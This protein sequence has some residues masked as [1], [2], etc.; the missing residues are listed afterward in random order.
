MFKHEIGK[1]AKDLVTGFKGIINVRAQYFTGCNRYGLISKI[2]K[3]GKIPET[4]WF[5]ENQLEIIGKGVVIEQTP[6]Q[7]TKGGPQPNPKKY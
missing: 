1:E 6:A 3:D 7:R 5:D 2:G 4:Q